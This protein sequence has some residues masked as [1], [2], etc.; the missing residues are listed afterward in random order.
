MSRTYRI[1][2]FKVDNN[3]MYLIQ[4]VSGHST[5]QILSYFHRMASG[6]IETY[7]TK[8]TLADYIKK[9]LH[10]HYEGFG[11][12]P[13]KM[14]ASAYAG[15]HR[16]HADG[17]KFHVDVAFPRSTEYVDITEAM[18]TLIE[19]TIG[20]DGAKSM[21]PFAAPRTKIPAGFRKLIHD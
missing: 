15:K 8:K 3:L 16:E 2:N 4:K 17:F 19:T 5:E 12:I 13:Y 9:E 20:L 18:N 11:Y 10:W 6:V 21:E 1:E 7:I 14:T